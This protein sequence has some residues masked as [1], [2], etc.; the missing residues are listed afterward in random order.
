MATLRFRRFDDYYYANGESHR[1]YVQRVEKAWEL[2][3]RELEMVGT[4]D[5]LKIAKSGPAKHAEDHDLKSLCVAVARE[6]EAL[7]DGFES[8][9][10]GHRDRLTEATIRAYDAS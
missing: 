8:S 4:S 3:I 5:P 6:F 9:E 2:R 1:Y 7:G 10:H